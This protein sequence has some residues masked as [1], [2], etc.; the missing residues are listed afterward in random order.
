MNWMKNKIILISTILLNGCLTEDKKT[1]FDPL[2]PKHVIQKSKSASIPKDSVQVYDTDTV[3]KVKEKLKKNF[4]TKFVNL[5]YELNKKDSSI[6]TLKIAEN[7][8]TFFI[9]NQNH[10]ELIKFRNIGFPMEFW[11][12]GGCSFFAIPY[13]D[14]ENKIAAAKSL[15]YNNYGYKCELI[16][17][18]LK[19][20]R[21]LTD[22]ISITFKKETSEEIRNKILSNSNFGKITLY[23]LVY[24]FNLINRKAKAMV[25]QF[26]ILMKNEHIEHVAFVFTSCDIRTP[27]AN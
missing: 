6:T 5:V 20:E 22:R 16:G 23:N 27:P 3:G 2:V 10:K 26:E 8:I 17:N 9:P 15:G 18:S 19:E 7:I 24:E 1:H 11:A 14:L 13:T 12:N 4:E 25:R 21:I